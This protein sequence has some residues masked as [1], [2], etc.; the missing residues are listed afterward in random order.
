MYIWSKRS[1]CKFNNF[2]FIK[3]ALILTNFILNDQSWSTGS[4][5]APAPA[6]I[7]LLPPLWHGPAPVLFRL[8]PHLWSGPTP[9]LIRLLPGPDQHTCW[10]MMVLIWS[11]DHVTF[12]LKNLTN[13]KNQNKSRFHGSSGSGLK[14]N[15]SFKPNLWPVFL[16]TVWT[17]WSVWCET[18]SGRDLL[19]WSGSGSG[20]GLVSFTNSHSSTVWWFCHFPALL[21]RWCSRWDGMQSRSQRLQRQTRHRWHHQLLLP[22]LQTTDR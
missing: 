10:S 14:S 17:A 8:L 15:W 13:N 20:P 18:R 1:F 9:A 19:C 3:G 22:V 11:I 16:F 6:L 21:R 5:L 4:D 2:Y 12:R 7:R